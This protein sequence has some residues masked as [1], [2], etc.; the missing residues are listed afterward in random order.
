MVNFISHAYMYFISIIIICNQIA[1]VFPLNHLKFIMH[2]VPHSPISL[3]SFWFVN[4]IILYYITKGVYN[5]Y[6]VKH[7]NKFIFDEPVYILY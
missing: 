3:N 7:V 2:P 1:P 6:Q 4:E 5:L